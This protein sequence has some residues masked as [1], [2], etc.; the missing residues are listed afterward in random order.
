[1]GTDSYTLAPAPESEDDRTRWLEHTAGFILFEDVR[2]YARARIDPA[3][4]PEVR[5]EIEKGID[6]AVYGLMMIM[7]GVTGI[8]SN[9]QEE[10]SLQFIARH[11]QSHEEGNGTVLAQADPAAAT[12]CA[13][14]STA[15]KRATSETP[16]CIRA[17]S[18]CL[19]GRVA[20]ARTLDITL[21]ESRI[22]APLQRKSSGARAMLEACARSRCWRRRV[23]MSGAVSSTRRSEVP[24]SFRVRAPMMDRQAATTGSRTSRRRKSSVATSMASR[25]RTGP[26][27][28]TRRQAVVTIGSARPPSGDSVATCQSS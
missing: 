17:R 18:T 13:A 4:T 2:G 27:C 6:D 16:P 24:T 20:E 1:M 7:D 19:W 28:P 22:G 15:G 25:R 14:R 8:L 3:V 12:A 21:A 9:E 5:A 26:A 23:R 11:V 10:V